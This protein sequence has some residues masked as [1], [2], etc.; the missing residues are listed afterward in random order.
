[1]DVKALIERGDQLFSKRGTLLTHWQD[2][3]DQFYPHRAD[4]TVTRTPG[5]DFADHLSTSYPALVHRDLSDSF[6]TMM[7]PKNIDWFHMAIRGREDLDQPAKAWLEY[8]TGI[9]RRAMYDRR[10]KFA[11]ASKE[12]D[13]DIAA[14]GQ[15][16]KTV[17][18]N[19]EAS[20]LL[21]RCWHLRDVTWCENAASAAVGSAATVS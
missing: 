5:D 16:V 10:A 2:L 1:M 21:F 4:F 11:R 20:G 18:L 19:R 13:R 8:A 14:F 7:R 15:A 6:S 17:E 9:Q 12:A 3:A